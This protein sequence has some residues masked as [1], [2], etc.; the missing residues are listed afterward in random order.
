M[1]GRPID[2]EAR[3]WLRWLGIPEI[4]WCEYVLAPAE[5]NYDQAEAWAAAAYD[6]G[7]QLILLSS[8]ETLVRPVVPLLV[9]PAGPKKGSGATNDR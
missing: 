8:G 5:L 3:D 6:E 9:R 7:Y 4:R 1:P 2:E